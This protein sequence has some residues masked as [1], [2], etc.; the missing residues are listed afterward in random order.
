MWLT[1]KMAPLHFNHKLWLHCHVLSRCYQFNAVTWCTNHDTFTAEVIH[2]CTRHRFMCYVLLSLHTRRTFSK[3]RTRMRIRSKTRTST[4]RA[5]GHG[6]GRQGQRK[7]LKQEEGQREGEGQGQGRGQ[8]L[9]KGQ[10]SGVGSWCCNKHFE[11]SQQQQQ[12]FLIK[13]KPSWQHWQLDEKCN[14]QCLEHSM[15]VSIIY[16][17]K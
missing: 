12:Q 8:V 13:L 17:T 3:T 7:G 16:E 14:W 6:Q 1:R 10:G 9:G 15:A 4:S 2:S 11:V 5:R